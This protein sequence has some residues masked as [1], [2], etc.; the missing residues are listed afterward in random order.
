VDTASALALLQEAEQGRAKGKPQG[1][2]SFR[3]TFKPVIERTK[4]TDTDKPKQQVV[5][6]ES[7]DKLAALKNYRRKNGLYFKCGD[8]WAKEH[9]C[10]PQVAIHVIEELLD[11]FEDIGIEDVEPDC[12]ALEEIVMAVGHTSTSDHTKRRTMKLCGSIGKNE[13]L[14]LVDSGS[15]ASFISNQLA[16]RLQLATVPCPPTNFVAADGSPM[17]CTRQ[18][19]NL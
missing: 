2:E 7:E 9:K 15:V 17:S 3:S 18:V 5:S 16:E 11:A 10:P 14:I 8:K 1:K 4:F 19:K 13:V 6:S 12:E